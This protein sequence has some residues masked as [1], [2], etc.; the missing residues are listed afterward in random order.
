MLFVGFEIQDSLAT[1][2]PMEI[3][4]DCWEKNKCLLDKHCGQNGKC[5]IGSISGWTTID[6]QSGSTTIDAAPG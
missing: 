2:E 1:S 4:K 6:A 5:L 3:R